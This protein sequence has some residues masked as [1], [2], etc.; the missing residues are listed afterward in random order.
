MEA[1][2]PFS[3]KMAE[4]TDKKLAAIL[5]FHPQDYQPEAIAAAA[6][7]LSKRN[8]SSTQLEILKAEIRKDE[9]SASGVA[10][11]K[12]SPLGIIL[13]VLVVTIVFG[14]YKFS[15]LGEDSTFAI[16]LLVAALAFAIG[17]GVAYL[18]QKAD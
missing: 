7:E 12:N 16:D 10:R 3:E 1:S 14:T 17:Q 8:L 2:N 18:V 13:K 9:Q 11:R 4:L 5:F 15:V 6:S